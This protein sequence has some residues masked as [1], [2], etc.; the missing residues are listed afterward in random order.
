MRKGK[1]QESHLY[2]KLKIVNRAGQE[3]KNCDIFMQIAPS[4]HYIPLH[5]HML[6]YYNDDDIKFYKYTH[7]LTTDHTRTY[8]LIMN[9]LYTY[10]NIHQLMIDYHIL[11]TCINGIYENRHH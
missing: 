1:E 6:N 9:I 3:G 5:S 11:L 4:I 8:N 7:E 10:T 2:I